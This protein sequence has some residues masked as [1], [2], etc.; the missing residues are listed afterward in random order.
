MHIPAF[1]V[2]LLSLVMAASPCLSQEAAPSTGASGDAQ[3]VADRARMHF[4]RGVE[5]YSA[6]NYDA[7]LAEFQRTQELRPNYKLLFNLAQVQ[8]E[9]HD[10]AAALQ[11]FSEYLRA[12]GASI[13]PERVSE[14]E[15]ELKRLR[16][17]VAELTFNIDVKGARVFV[18]AAP[19]GVSP[20]HEPVLVNAGSALIRVEK[21]GYAPFVESVNIAGADRRQLDVTLEPLAAATRA[22]LAQPD[23]LTRTQILPVPNMTPFWISLGATLVLGGATATFGVLSLRAHADQD[24]LLTRYPGRP[25]EL[26]AAGD[27]LQSYALLTDVSAGATLVAGIAALYFV[28]SP[29]ER[30]ETAP[31]RVSATPAGFVM[32]GAF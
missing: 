4:E 20:L 23:V 3:S 18:D 8:V 30:S 9:R 12:G 16:E 28:L 21:G 10:N 13:A 27:R 17:S 14:V 6:G 19:V 25:S 2:F 26:R 1:A 5:H 29:P 11:L 22:A 32:A 24:A 31:L 15:Q 7:A